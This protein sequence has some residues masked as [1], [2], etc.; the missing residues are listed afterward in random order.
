LINLIEGNFS[1]ADQDLGQE[2]SLEAEPREL[3]VHLLRDRLHLAGAHVGCDSSHV[4][5]AV[6]IEHGAGRSG[7]PRQAQ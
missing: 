1:E 4:P 6:K 2:R 3:L 7:E 5:S